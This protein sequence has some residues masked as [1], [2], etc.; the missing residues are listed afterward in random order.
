MDGLGIEVW[1]AVEEARALMALI[2]E[3]IGGLQ[4]LW[5][6]NLTAFTLVVWWYENDARSGGGTKGGC[7]AGPLQGP[8]HERV[9]SD[10]T[11]SDL[12]VVC[13]PP[14]PWKMGS[15]QRLLAGSSYPIRIV[16]PL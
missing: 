16:L 13:S 3:V 14:S 11:E 7:G 5:C 4:R 15:V 6:M 12:G 10:T 2:R 1:G 9:G 8:G